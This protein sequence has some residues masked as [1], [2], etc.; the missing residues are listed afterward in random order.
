MTL[1]SLVLTNRKVTKSVYPLVEDCENNFSYNWN[2]IYG[3][4]GERLLIVFLN[5]YGKISYR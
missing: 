5:C 1:G 3:S 4:F 2:I